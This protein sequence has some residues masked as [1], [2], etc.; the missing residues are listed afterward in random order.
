MRTSTWI[1]SIVLASLIAAPAAHAQDTNAPPGNSGIDQYLETVPEADGSKP[2][3]TQKPE[4]G[5]GLP[6]DTAAE[7]DAAGDDG[8]DVAALV[9]A[10]GPKASGGAKGGGKAAPDQPSATGKGASKT[11]GDKSKD[12]VAGVSGPALGGT[13]SDGIGPLLPAVL[14]LS[15]AAAIGFLVRRRRSE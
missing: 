15:G 12:A 9:A 3:G 1:L 5:S 7:L 10:T 2:P 4:S 8:A 6:A 14:I 11:A 13:G